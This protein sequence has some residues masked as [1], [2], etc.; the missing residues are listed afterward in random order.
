ML[1]DSLV[2]FVPVGA[3]LSLIS[4]V[5]DIPSTN[6]VDLMGSGPGT[7]VSNIIGNASQPGMDVGV[8]GVRPEL[9]ITIGDAVVSGGGGTVNF[10][11]QAAPNT[12]VTNQPGSWTTLAETGPI[13]AA[14]LT[15]GQIVA[16]FPFL[17]AFPAGLNPRFLRIV[18]TIATASVTAGSIAS[19]LV[20]NY[21]DDQANKYAAGNFTVA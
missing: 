15:A 3:P 8:G 11:L 9:N 20:T 10:K 13:T 14:N 21:R 4:A 2:S 7:A 16:R 5:G 6:V 19:A 18:A 12:D 17:P 1:T